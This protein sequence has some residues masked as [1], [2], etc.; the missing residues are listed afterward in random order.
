M[1]N[2]ESFDDSDAVLVRVHCECVFGDV[3]GGRSGKLLNAAMEKI[4][5]EQRGVIVYL[6]GQARIEKNYIKF[7]NK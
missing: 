4:A 5:N 1:G 7:V 2:I 6:R 3:F